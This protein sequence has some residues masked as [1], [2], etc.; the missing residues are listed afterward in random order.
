MGTPAPVLIG[1]HEVFA[2][3]VRALAEPPALVLIE[4]EAGIGKTRL[5]KDCLADASLS[6]RTVLVAACPPL[7]EPFPLG[8]IVDGLRRLRQHINDVP[9]SPLGGALRPLFPEWG[10]ELP[11]ELTPLGDPLATRHRVFS[12][13]NE[14]V[15]RI[16]IDVL[17]VEDVHWADTATLEWLLTRC[18][19]GPSPPDRAGSVVLTYRPQEVPA[20]SPLRRL[21]SRSSGGMRQVRLTLEPLSPEQTRQLVAAMFDT[22]QV[23][24]RFAA[25]LHEHTDGIPLAVEEIVLLLRDRH[26]VV[27]RGG[28]WARRVLDELHVPPTVRDSVLERIGR[29]DPDARAVLNAAAVLAAPAGEALLTTVAGLDER[30]GLAGVAAALATGL[31]QETGPDRLVFRHALDCKAVSETIPAPQRRWLHRRAACSLEDV[32]PKPI[33]RLARHFKEA[34]DLDKWCHYAELTAQLALTS[35]D[36]RTAVATLHELLT[37]AEHPPAERAR[38][39]LTLGQVA[40][41]CMV[42]LGDLA[43][44]VTEALRHVLDAGGLEPPQRGELRLQLGRL[45]RELTQESAAYQEIEKAI[46]DLEHHPATAARAML[47]LALPLVPDWPASRHRYWLRRAGAIPRDTMTARDRLS[48][49]T[50]EAT[51]LLLLGEDSGWDVAAR[52]PERADSSDDRRIIGQWLLNCAQVTAVWGR[53][54]EARRRLATASAAISAVSYSRR[55][56]TVAVAAAYLDW[57]TGSW[58]GLRER[59][60]ELADSDDTVALDRLQARLIVGLLDLVGGARAAA[61]SR[62][63]E[64]VD[65]FTRLGAAEPAVVIA[66][67]ALGR[68]YLA[69][70]VAEAALRATGP[71]VDMIARKDVWLWAT[72]VVAVHIEALIGIGDLV[73]AE[74]VVDRLASWLRERHPPAPHAALLTSQA[75]VAQGRGDPRAAAG[76]FAEA[77]AAW[78]ELPRPYDALLAAERQGLALHAAGEHSG[79]D[80]LTATQQRL[81]ELGAAWDADRVARVLRQHGVDVA[82]AWRRGP[83]GY[84]DQLSPRERQVVALVSR[85]MTNRQIGTA[86]FLS[87]KTVDRH[88]RASM[89][90]LGVSSRTALAMAAADAGLLSSGGLHS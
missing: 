18:T 66:P 74:A 77:A 39:A 58:T 83:R 50:N 2:D 90:K 19:S 82:R 35:G 17:V 60:V 49:A 64:V 29:L 20:D 15:S 32:Q 57:Y 63:R 71:V 16:G 78:A 85:G 51:A 22:D 10:A 13:L 40:A 76:G 53:Y 1:R 84:G 28:A 55:T 46:A 37:A 8:P 38:L 21:T 31:L 26:D 6:G 33:V 86:L 41:F 62:L 87:P 59:A 67:A 36:D 9:L 42:T 27:R 48:M 88:V 4:G 81:R 52:I 70:G 43:A 25:F 24:E 80:V 54:A 61:E 7:R 23:S 5:L 75:L 45:L 72:D 3:A 44:Q 14:L 73:R 68:L 69:D 30:A 47:T 11:P 56:G 34:G 12:A 89:R 79:L 65:E